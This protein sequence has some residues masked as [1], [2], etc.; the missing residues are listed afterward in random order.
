VNDGRLEHNGV[1]MS[2]TRVAYLVARL[3]IQLLQWRLLLQLSL[4]DS[5]DNGSIRFDVV[6]IFSLMHPALLLH[7]YYRYCGFT[8]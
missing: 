1:K 5:D 7:S 4:S 6:E 2:I 3:V 8:D